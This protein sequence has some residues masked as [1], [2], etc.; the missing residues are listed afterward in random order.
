MICVKS[1]IKINKWLNQTVY[2]KVT[3]EQSVNIFFNTRYTIQSGI[4]F[5]IQ[6]V[7]YNWISLQLRTC[8]HHNSCLC[9]SQRES[10]MN[11]H[12][13]VSERVVRR[14]A[15]LLHPEPWTEVWDVRHIA[16]STM[17]MLYIYILYIHICLCDIDYVYV[18]SITFM[19]WVKIC[20]L[21]IYV[22]F[23]EMFT[24][25]MLCR[26]IFTCNLSNMYVYVLYD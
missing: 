4:E 3:G 25:Y 6:N 7:K 1:I 12:E 21:A 16:M 9:L 15:C 26:E 23:L 18:I 2:K 5:K 14:A 10:S 13:I 20:L 24:L 19:L 8:L 22:T 17:Y 11:R